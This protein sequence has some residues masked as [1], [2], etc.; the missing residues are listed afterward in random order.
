M[1][2]SARPVTAEP[3]NFAVEV[4][5]RYVSPLRD[6][7]VGPYGESDVR[8]GWS[9]TPLFTIAVV[10]YDL[11]QRRHAEFAGER[12]VPRRGEV[13]VTWRF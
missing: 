11:L 6:P 8:L 7:R 13:Q 9:P 4:I 12:Y 5:G 2:G 10:G 3:A 1:N